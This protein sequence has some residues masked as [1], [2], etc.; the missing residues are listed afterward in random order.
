MILSVGFLIWFVFLLILSIFSQRTVIFYDALGQTD[1]SA[2]FSSKLPLLR[3]LI[4]PFYV[5]AYVLEMEFTWMFLF[6]M[7]YP[8]IRGLYLYL[9]RKG[10]FNSEKYRHISYPISDIV[11]FCFKVLS[12]SILIVGIYILI[13]YIAQG[14]FFVSRYFMIPVQIAA[15]LCLI[16]IFIKIGVTVLKF[17]LPKQSLNLFRKFFKAKSRSKLKKQKIKKE[18]VYYVGIGMLLLSINI[19]FIS[20]PF[21]NHEIIPI[22]PLENDEFL[23]D[24]HIH[25]TFSD[26]WL[27]VEERI[28]WYIQQGISGAVFIDHDNIRGATMAI[29]YVT[30]HGLDFGVFMGEE[31]TDNENDIH[32][33]YFGL[34]EEIVPLQSYTPGG[35]MALNASDT[36]SY[37]KA[38]GGYIFVNHYNYDPNPEGGFGVPYTLTQLKDWGVDGFEIVN[39]GSYSGKYLL[40]RQF[41]LDNNLTCIGGSDIHTNE[42][43][44]TFIKMRLTDP[45]N[46][47]VVNIFETLKNN[48]HQVIAVDLYP[49]LVDFP[50]DLNDFGFYILQDFINYL[51]NMDFYQALSWIFWS[52]SV[53]TVFV[54]IYRKVKKI[55]LRFLKTKIE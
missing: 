3:Y 24:F 32:M 12:I 17:I 2:E 52:S 22:I 55:E 50:S 1:V 47:T 37:V 29:D 10:K 45:T 15:H 30:E 49:E 20:T 36:I 54:L 43:L 11:Y 34:A 16:L 21:P 7:F 25:T 14:Y 35:P 9:R 8:I 28:N 40:I 26:G 27:T 53:Y 48:T 38:H 19:V 39:G 33:N 44:N 42:D 6:L 4:E 51:L 13:G 23:F 5:I 41:C 31:W 46:L 18:I